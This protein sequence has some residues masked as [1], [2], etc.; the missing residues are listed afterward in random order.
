MGASKFC[1]CLMRRVLGRLRRAISAPE[2]VSSS[3]LDA[4]PSGLQRAAELFS[5]TGKRSHLLPRCHSVF[6]TTVFLHRWAKENKTLICPPVLKFFL[7]LFFF[8]F[9]L[10]RLCSLQSSKQLFAA[11]KRPCCSKMCRQRTC[12]SPGCLAPGRA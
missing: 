5:V 12:P 1:P 8:F 4:N 11:S 7:F 3:G 2:S 9:F 6:L 10:N